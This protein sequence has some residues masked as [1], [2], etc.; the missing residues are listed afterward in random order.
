MEIKVAPPE[1]LADKE[2]VVVCVRVRAEDGLML[3]DNLT[4]KC[5]ECQWTIQYRPNAPSIGTK[6][7]LECALDA[8]EA[9]GMPSE[10]FLSQEQMD[11]YS[12]RK[13]FK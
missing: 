7:C 1:V 10:I 13:G 4:G 5:S 9:E 2:T 11:E 6:V 3:P 12:K 8:F